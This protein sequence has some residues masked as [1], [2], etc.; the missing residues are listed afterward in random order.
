MWP[1]KQTKE[2]I[3]SLS[4]TNV[5]NRVTIYIA[6]TRFLTYFPLWC[7]LNL[8]LSFSVFP[9]MMWT[10][11]LYISDLVMWF[12]H[13]FSIYI[14]S[15]DSLEKNGDTCLFLWCLLLIFLSVIAFWFLSLICICLFC[16]CCVYSLFSSPSL[17]PFCSSCSY[18]VTMAPC[19][20]YEYLSLLS[21]F[22]EK[23]F[24]VVLKIF[25]CHHASGM[26]IFLWSLIYMQYFLFQNLW[27][28]ESNPGTSQTRQVLFLW[29]TFV[30][31]TDF[32]ICL[33]YFFPLSFYNIARL[34]SGLC[35]ASI[36]FIYYYCKIHAWSMSVERYFYEL[37]E[38]QL[39]YVNSFLVPPTRCISPTIT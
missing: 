35:F 7:F 13:Y 15:P 22:P 14:Y 33:I 2:L 23:L 26:F 17:N 11:F 24:P 4:A 39:F 3:L 1:K 5:W 20:G 9:F 6:F 32:R 38:K 19:L 10:F 34:V 25:L 18:T 16:S 21:P 8:L 30:P 37:S 31:G 29:A 27:C 28:Q 36:Y 12:N